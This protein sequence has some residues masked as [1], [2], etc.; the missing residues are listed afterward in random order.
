MW[1]DFH[2]PLVAEW[3]TFVT[4]SQVALTAIKAVSV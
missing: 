4:Y 3:E 1:R 2:Q